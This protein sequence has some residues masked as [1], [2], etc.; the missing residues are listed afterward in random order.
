MVQL[1]R[2]RALLTAVLPESSQVLAGAEGRSPATQR[3]RE[4]AQVLNVQR[5]C[6]FK[7]MLKLYVQPILNGY[8]FDYIPE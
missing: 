4:G 2:T 8:I 5:D 7:P 6:M 3:E 1:M